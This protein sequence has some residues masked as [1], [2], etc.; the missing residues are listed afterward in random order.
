MRTI[1]RVGL[2]VWVYSCGYDS[3]IWVHGPKV[4]IESERGVRKSEP[5]FDIKRVD[6][7]LAM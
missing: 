7:L 3:F 1:I 4:G 2:F 5:A 6:T